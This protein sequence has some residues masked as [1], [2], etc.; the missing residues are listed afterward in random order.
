MKMDIQARFIRHLLCLCHGL[1][2]FLAACTAFAASPNCAETL[3][4]HQPAQAIFQELV[5]L[6]SEIAAAQKSG[7]QALALTMARNF[8]SKLKQATAAGL[9]ISELAHLKARAG[10]ISGDLNEIEDKRREN[11]IAS[12]AKWAPWRLLY[13]VTSPDR[14]KNSIAVEKNNQQVATITLDNQIQIWDISSGKLITEISKPGAA[15]S[16]MNFSPDGTLIATA[17]A[18][19]IARIRDAKTGAV[20]HELLNSNVVSDVKF[21]PDGSKVLTGSRDGAARLWDTSSGIELLT[22]QKPYHLGSVASVN[23]SPDGSRAVVLDLSGGIALFD[24]LTG[25]R[26]RTLQDRIFSSST[27]TVSPDG[28]TLISVSGRDLASLFDLQ[29]NLIIRKLGYTRG[30][31]SAPVSDAKFNA[32]GSLI[33]SAESDY[34]VRIRNNHDGRIKKEFKGHSGRITNVKFSSDDRRILSQGD[35]YKVILWDVDDETPLHIFDLSKHLG[36]MQTGFSPDGKS[37]FM[38]TLDGHLLIF[39]QPPFPEAE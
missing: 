39:K 35:D 7:Q 38:I 1:L 23:F 16:L 11:A 13:D 26:E 19:R 18:D 24:T 14:F 17:S 33:L 4:D 30:R 32:D 25:K 3:N 34:L 2:F 20:S 5:D 36:A 15:V 12:E 27:A 10:E 9:P 37:I 8:A 31:P 6:R 28:K 22:F 21:S 29:N